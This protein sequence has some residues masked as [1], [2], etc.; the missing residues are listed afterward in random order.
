MVLAKETLLAHA[1]LV[2]LD[3]GVAHL[4]PSHIRTIR[5]F[6]IAH[7]TFEE[8]PLCGAGAIA[9]RRMFAML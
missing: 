7:I 4:V 1:T 3:A 5:E 8:F 6:H 2:R 9:V